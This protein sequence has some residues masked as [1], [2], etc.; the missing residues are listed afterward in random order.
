MKKD[1]HFKMKFV[2]L[3]IIFLTIIVIV[4]VIITKKS[5][6]KMIVKNDNYDLAT[7][8]SISINKED[9]NTYNNSSSKNFNENN[10]SGPK[11][12]ENSNLLTSSETNTMPKL[13]LSKAELSLSTGESETL[14]ASL[15]NIK[16]DAT[17]NSS[18]N[19]IATIDKDGKITTLMSGNIFISA[20]SKD[21]I[22][23]ATCSLTVKY[24]PDYKL[25]QANH[26]GNSVSNILNGGF[27]A[28]Q[29]NWIYYRNDSDN[30]TLYKM[31]K[32]G[33]G[34]RKICNDPVSNI[35]VVGD[36][37]YFTSSFGTNVSGYIHRVRTDGSEYKELASDI[38]A[39][40]LYV[41]S[42]AMYCINGNQDYRINKINLDGSN[43]STLNDYKSYN[44][45]I[46][47]NTIFYCAEAPNGYPFMRMTMDGKNEIEFLAS[48]TNRYDGV[49]LENDIFY[50]ITDGYISGYNKDGQLI[51]Y[52]TNIKSSYTNSESFCTNN[53]AVCVSNNFVFYIDQKD[54]PKFN[55]INLDNNQNIL[56]TVSLGS[57]ARNLNIVDGWI[58]YRVETDDGYILKKI[59]IYGTDMQYVD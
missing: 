30:G 25:G 15:N 21:G 53:G 57:Y 29:D 32:D 7:T 47:Q 19:T 17:W 59:R 28:Q 56:I 35:N 34:K 42:E 10:T 46:S 48:K 2:V 9:N 14:I 24:V 23:K 22:Y 44:L 27:V 54:F 4:A 13:V 45:I 12:Q 38:L 43:I 52:S 55:R 5:A 26:I 16:I 50:C 20:I 31:K 36:W 33:T 11:S 6:D 40:N 1:N 51:T 39:F 18:D 49:Y 41:T 37:V 3:F 58:Y 8:S